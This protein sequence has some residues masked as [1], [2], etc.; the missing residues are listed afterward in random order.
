MST[1]MIING[2]RFRGTV[3]LGLSTS[4]LMHV[5]K[6]WYKN[7]PKEGLKTLLFDPPTLAPH[8]SSSYMAYTSSVHV[9]NMGDIFSIFGAFL[10]EPRLR[11]VLQ[12]SAFVKLDSCLLWVNPGL[13]CTILRYFV[14]GVLSLGFY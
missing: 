11:F 10:V 14:L 5:C 9:P 12:L 6:I 7:N 13:Y 8:L 1:N 2:V 3:F 4:L